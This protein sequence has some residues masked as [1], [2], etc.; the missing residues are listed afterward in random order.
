MAA[1]R[2]AH[3]LTRHRWTHQQEPVPLKQL[4]HYNRIVPIV[5]TYLDTQPINFLFKL[6]PPTQQL[7]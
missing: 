7:N 3:P 4:F 6:H 2:S 5:I 1:A